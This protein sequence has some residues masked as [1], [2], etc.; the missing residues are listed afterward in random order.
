MVYTTPILTMDVISVVV[1][2]KQKLLVVVDVMKW[3]VKLVG[4]SVKLTLVML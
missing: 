4:G 3:L 1:I 2:L